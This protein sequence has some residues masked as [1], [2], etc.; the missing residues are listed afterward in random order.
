MS[1]GEP[2]FRDQLARALPDAQLLLQAAVIF[3]FSTHHQESAVQPSS[4][5]DK[6][7]SVEGGGETAQRVSD[8]KSV[9]RMR[10]K[11]LVG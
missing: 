5:L 6:A 7:G 8:R 11:T 10:K 9:G 2:K 3:V 4:A 1:T